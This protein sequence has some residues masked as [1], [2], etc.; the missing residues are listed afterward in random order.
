MNRFRSLASLPIPHCM[1]ATL[2]ACLGTAILFA[3]TGCTS[4]KVHMGMK[5]YLAKTPVSSI[6]VSLPKGPGIAPGEKSPLVVVVTETMGSR[7]QMYVAGK[8]KANGKDL[9]AL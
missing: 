7:L 2:Q 4:M 3:L 8:G 5:V 6:A 1:I 9:S